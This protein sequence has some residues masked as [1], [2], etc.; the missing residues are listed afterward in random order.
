MLHLDKNEYYGEDTASFSF[1]QLLDWVDNHQHSNSRTRKGRDAADAGPGLLQNTV[2]N[3]TTEKNTI[4]ALLLDMETVGRAMARG[5][6]RHQ[7]KEDRKLEC[8][9]AEQEAAEQEAAEQQKCAV[10]ASEGVGT[11]QEI[12]GQQQQQEPGAAA[13]FEEE[14]AEHK[15]P[16]NI[17]GAQNL[18]AHGDD[19]DHDHDR[20]KTGQQE[21]E[22]ERR[23]EKEEMKKEEEDN[24]IVDKNAAERLESLELE[25][26]PLSHHGCRT[27]AGTPSD[28]CTQERLLQKA[29]EVAAAASGRFERQPRPSHPAWIGARAPCKEAAVG[30][31]DEEEG[32]EEVLHPAFWGYRTERRP[33]AADLVRLSRSFNLDLTSQVGG[34]GGCMLS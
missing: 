2:E 29:A 10:G 31:R 8:K 25:L 17:N 14:E 27:R 16:V 19:G 13:E 6:A 21:E 28:S 23:E 34:V 12:E 30:G 1:T 32:K 9:A 7:L 4:D 18:S 33:N 24:A 5:H 20:I 3:S 11:T 22:E 26:L 15:S